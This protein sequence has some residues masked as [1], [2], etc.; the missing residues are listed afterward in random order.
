M[1][2]GT[3]VD[4]VVTSVGY[5]KLMWN[6]YWCGRSRRDVPQVNYNESSEEEFDSPL[7]SPT[8]PPPTRAASPV[9]LAVPTLADN[10]DEE[11]S[12]VRQQLQNVGH[13][14]AFRGTRPEPEG[15]PSSLGEAEVSV[16]EVV[17]G[18][19]VQGAS[20]A[21]LG[22]GGSDGSS[23]E[24][25][26]MPNQVDYDAEDVD[27]G[28]KAQEH[29]RSVKVDFDAAD[30]RFWFSQLEAEMTM[31]TVNSQWL[32][33]TILQRNL[34]NK[35]KEDVKELLTLPKT[36]AGASIYLDIKTELIRIYAPKPQ[37]AYQKALTRA[38]VGLPSQLG[39]QIINDICKKPKKLQG[40]CCDQA[41]L[42]IWSMKLPVNVRA[43]ISNMEFT[44]D[45]YKSVFEAADKVFS[46]SRQISVAAMAVSDN[47]D[48]TQAA[49]EAMN[50][51]Q[52][53]AFAA[54]NSTKSSKPLN[55]GGGNKN[56]KNNKNNKG[57]GNK[58]QNQS[59]SR[60]PRHSSSPPE[61]C[62]DRHYRHGPEAWYC[63]APLTCPLGPPKIFGRS[64][65]KLHSNF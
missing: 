41:A 23:S 31:A 34:P 40:C 36:Q 18:L 62:C 42:A 6:N 14:H 32:K 44:K 35:Q 37:D 65:L 17:E 48:E 63:V 11:L 53:A 52:V 22:D 19:V 25:D 9:L 28:A 15:Q 30:I 47:L 38:M 45:T 49:F 33:K 39:Q 58:N 29:A 51:P 12:L 20:G 64:R 7:Q 5:T 24:D 54:K 43:H 4:V 21:K 57:K 27:D 13:T 61:A 56:N 59:S 60:G 26:A 10:V 8:R 1:L 3:E 16:E 2:E 55:S 46:S 50:Q